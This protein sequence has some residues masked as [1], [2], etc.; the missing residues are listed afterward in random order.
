MKYRLSVKFNK[1]FIDVDEQKKAIT[2]GVR[3]KPVKG[4]AN[5]EIMKKLA[6]HFSVPSS[7]VRII[8]GLRSKNKIVEINGI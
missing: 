8:M 1:D 5:A 4:K 2:I 6:E 3:S 7:R